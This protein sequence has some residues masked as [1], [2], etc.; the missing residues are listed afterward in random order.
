MR[1]LSQKAVAYCK[2]SISG[3]A[4]KTDL[5]KELR[6][7]FARAALQHEAARG[8]SGDGWAEYQKIY[9]EHAAEVRLQE[10]Q[11]LTEYQSRFE[12]TRRKIIDQG[13]LVDRKPAPRWSGRDGFG[14][15]AI[16]HQAD[17]EVR[18]AHDALLERMKAQRETLVDKLF[19][20]HGVS[21]RGAQEL[22]SDFTRATDRRSGQERRRGPP[23]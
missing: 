4:M 15:A 17:R 9:A 18:M 16:D 3:A 5:G 1:E 12:A 20:T 7:L 22:K 19:E 21:P 13:G 23:R 6:Q 14:A 8:L 2:F 11:Y 10:R